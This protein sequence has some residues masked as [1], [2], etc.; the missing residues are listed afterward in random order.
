VLASCHGPTAPRQPQALAD[1]T[2]TSDALVQVLLPSSFRHI[3][4]EWEVFLVNVLTSCIRLE[5]CPQHSIIQIVLQ[6][7][8][9]D[10]S[11]L[12]ACVHASVSALMDASVELNYL[13]VAISCVINT[14]T[15][16]NNSDKQK[17]FCLD[18]TLV[19]EEQE[20]SGSLT[21]VV[22]GAE[23][24]CTQMGAIHTSGIRATVQD[25]MKCWSMAQ[26]AASAVTTFWRLALTH[27]HKQHAQT[28]FAGVINS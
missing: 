28:L 17:E 3:S 27:K 11:V 20:K 19:E 5:S 6:I 7:P 2:S 15:E 10:G 12:A 18:P 9:N 24:K 1:H 25:I 22:V 23:E 21:M 8:S 13:P 16:T 26:Q 14:P 4:Y